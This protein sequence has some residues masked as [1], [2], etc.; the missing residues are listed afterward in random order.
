MRACG[1]RAARDAVCVS[2]SYGAQRDT[3][4]GVPDPR[5]FSTL[6]ICVQGA[7]RV[8][9]RAEGAS[10][11]SPNLVVSSLFASISY[12]SL[13]ASTV[14]EVYGRCSGDGGDGQRGVWVVLVGA[15]GTAEQLTEARFSCRREDQTRSSH[16]TP[17]QPARNSKRVRQSAMDGLDAY[18]DLRLKHERGTVE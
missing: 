4:P 12:S 14:R 10:K 16:L 15:Y 11:E 17:Q 6:N 5:P 9:W 13:L 18:G 8:S 7:G 1:V 3:V 2:G